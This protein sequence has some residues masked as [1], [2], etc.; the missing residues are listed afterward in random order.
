MT[1]ASAPQ[2]ASARSVNAL[3]YPNGAWV[4]CPWCAGQRRFRTHV[5]GV[6]HPAWIPCGWCFGTGETYR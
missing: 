6:T 1:V 5:D 3:P 2:M 4:P